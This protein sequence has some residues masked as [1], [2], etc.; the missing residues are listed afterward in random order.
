MPVHPNT[1]QSPNRFF[2]PRGG[3][4]RARPLGNWEHLQDPNPGLDTSYS[5]QSGEHTNMPL[6]TEQDNEVTLGA[7][8][9]QANMDD[10]LRTLTEVLSVRDQG[11]RQSIKVNCPKFKGESGEKPEPHILSAEDWMDHHQ[12]DNCNRGIQFKH[13]LEGTARSWYNNLSFDKTTKWREVKEEFRSHFSEHGRTTRVV[14]DKWKSL[15]FDPDSGDIEEYIRNVKETSELLGHSDHL[16]LETL[17]GGMPNAIYA[18]IKPLATWDEVVA[19]LRDIYTVPSQP[20]SAKDATPAFPKANLHTLQQPCDNKKVTFNEQNLLETTISKLTDAVN[21]LS[22]Q[23]PRGRGPYKPQIHPGRGRGRSFQHQR[24]PRE[25]RGRG[26]SPD[27]RERRHGRTRSDSR[28]RG[29]PNFHHSRARFDKSPT[30]R[31]PR[32][33]SRGPNRDDRRCYKCH[34]TGHYARN[35]PLNRDHRDSRS[36]T[37]TD[38]GA[39]YNALFNP[40]NSLTEGTLDALN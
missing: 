19:V 24:F 29:R 35:C 25:D 31:R 32:S 5:D 33:S 9:T 37:E 21:T 28:N 10:L 27:P 39:S 36:K 26:R 38:L 16:K 40:D 18:S 11:A 3:R 13:T 12:V 23:K 7:R 6:E 17:K 8:Q 1:F 34:E 2:T 15:K 14:L 22:H 20:S 4:G 30:H